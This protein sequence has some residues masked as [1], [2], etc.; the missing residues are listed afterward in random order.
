MIP[1]F[2]R[3]GV[4]TSSAATRFFDIN[5]VT[6]YGWYW[7]VIP[8]LTIHEKSVDEYGG[9]M[10]LGRILY[11]ETYYGYTEAEIAPLRQWVEETYDLTDMS[12]AEFYIKLQRKVFEWKDEN[13]Y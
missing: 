1:T 5:T 4:V 2:L 11:S 7:D 12:Q 9:D 8:G 13:G 10:L 3:N 6:P